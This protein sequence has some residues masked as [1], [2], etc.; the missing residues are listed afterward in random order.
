MTQPG[1]N[2]RLFRF[3]VRDPLFFAPRLLFLAPRLLFFEPGLS[4]FEKVAK[5]CKRAYVGQII[6]IPFQY[7]K[8]PASP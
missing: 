6:A 7:L 3:S 4:F 8:A 1:L 2:A 5:R